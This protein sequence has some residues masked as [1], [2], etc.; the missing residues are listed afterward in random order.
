LF[1]LFFFFSGFCCFSPSPIVS[2]HRLHCSL[3]SVRKQ[4][5]QWRMRERFAEWEI[6]RMR[7]ERCEKSKKFEI[8]NKVL[9]WAVCR[10][11]TNPKITFSLVMD[12]KLL[13]VNTKGIIETYWIPFEEKYEEFGRNMTIMSQLYNSKKNIK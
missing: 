8:Q 5:K 11:Y 2:F 6:C 12:Q 4:K 13:C 3:K 9:C 7:K 1:F 10:A